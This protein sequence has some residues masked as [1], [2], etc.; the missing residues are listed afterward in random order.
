MDRIDVLSS[1]V[2]ILEKMLLLSTNFHWNSDEEYS[3]IFEAGLHN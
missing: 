1:N 2:K 3:M